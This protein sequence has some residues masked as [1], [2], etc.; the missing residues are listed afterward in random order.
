MFRILRRTC[1]FTTPLIIVFKY[2]QVEN[3]KILKL[4]LEKDPN[5]T[6]KNNKGQTAIDITKS[7]SVISL[8]WEYLTKGSDKVLEDVNENVPKTNR[9]K[10]NTYVPVSRLK[11]CTQ[12]V[13]SPQISQCSERSS[14]TSHTH[15]RIR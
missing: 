9:T 13:R 14:V 12:E 15:Y 4:L 5:L 7:K 2:L 8:F 10:Q 3:V 6:I 11:K 1:L